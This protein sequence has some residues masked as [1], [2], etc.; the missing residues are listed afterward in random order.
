MADNQASKDMTA[1]AGLLAGKRSEIDALKRKQNDLWESYNP[2]AGHGKFI[3]EDKKQEYEDLGEKI[4][5]AQRLYDILRSQM[6]SEF[7]LLAVYGAEGEANTKALASIAKGGDDAANTI[8]PMIVNKLENVQKARNG[9]QQKDRIWKNP[10]ILNG[11]KG[12]LGIA[13]DSVEQKLVDDKVHQIASDEFWENLLMG[14]VAIGLGLIAAIPTGGLSVAAAVGVAAAGT[15]SAGLSVYQAGK[16]LS[17]YQLAQA[18]NG[19]DFQKARAISQ[20]DPSLMWLAL[21]IVAAGF[22][23]KG[24]VTVFKAVS[25]PVRSA[26]AARSAAKEMEALGRGT[27][28]A[29]A[30]EK[31][32][33]DA[34]KNALQD[35]PEVAKR[36]MQHIGGAEGPKSPGPYTQL[37]TKT[38]GDVYKDAEMA[39]V[40]L[41]DHP[42]LAGIEA[43]LRPTGATLVADTSMAG[44][45]TANVVFIKVTGPEGASFN[46]ALI[47][48]RPDQAV[49]Q[50]LWHELNHLQDFQTGRVP[51]SYLIEAGDAARFGELEAKSLPD[52]IQVGRSA[53]PKI[54]EIAVTELGQSQARMFV[55][56]MRNHLRD[57][58]E[59]LK[60]RDSGYV[61]NAQKAV[62]TYRELLTN[63]VKTGNVRGSR[64][65][66]EAERGALRDYIRQ[67]ISEQFPELPAEYG[68]LYPSKSFW[69]FLQ[70]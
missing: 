51:P 41:R 56:E 55:A 23:V 16:A 44:S 40:L 30:K 13:A 64:P 9:L 38:G 39:T 61:E 17:E 46:R 8:V 45:A 36:V 42:N 12:E 34:L 32:E 70:E 31:Q 1:A 62:T 48:Y 69:A 49:L 37:A 2:L 24:A 59:L 11:T 47:R 53:A 21:D 25:A 10:T 35:K 28:E 15:A 22:D 19:T 54:G 57:I 27:V 65:L 20:E 67:Y 18:E 52:L 26:I 3:P 60:A 58:D 6:E 43:S 68:K 66:T 5:E 63:M 14:A 4:K 7:P 50:D 29:A 33:M